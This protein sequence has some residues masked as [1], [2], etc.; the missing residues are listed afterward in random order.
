MSARIGPIL[1]AAGGQISLEISRIV[2]SFEGSGDE[3]ADK[4]CGD[5]RAVERA[6][7]PDGIPKATKLS[8]SLVRLRTAV[9]PTGTRTLVYRVRA[10][11]PD[12]LD[13]REVC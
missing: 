10:G 11:Y 8:P 6:S 3:D 13:Y 9:F 12:Q 4:S 5:E 1:L 2:V 7:S